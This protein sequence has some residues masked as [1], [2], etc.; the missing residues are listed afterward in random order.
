MRIRPDRLQLCRTRRGAPI[1]DMFISRIG[2][3]NPIAK[4]G[5]RFFIL[6]LRDDSPSHPVVFGRMPTS[7]RIAFLP[8]G[9]LSVLAVRELEVKRRREGLDRKGEF[10]VMHKF[11][12][13]QHRKVNEMVL[14]ESEEALVEF[15]A[16]STVS[17]TPS[18]EIEGLFTF[19]RILCYTALDLL[20][21]IYLYTYETKDGGIRAKDPRVQQT[22]HW[23]AGKMEVNEADSA[24]VGRDGNTGDQSS[25]L[26]CSSPT[27]SPRPP[28]PPPSPVHRSRTARERRI[29]RVPPP[30]GHLVDTSRTPPTL[31]RAI[32]SAVPEREV[33]MHSRMREEEGYITN[34]SPR[35]GAS[36]VG[37]RLSASFETWA[38]LTLRGSGEEKRG[39]ELEQE[40]KSYGKTG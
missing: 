10:F 5:V 29:I 2:H 33:R 15:P 28:P 13:S 34:L 22:V 40:D 38:H 17:S 36:K 24:V 18:R 7:L 30:S 8:R 26:S 31:H 12:G 35:S 32:D 14:K 23:G 21:Y 16:S 25:L 11:H 1:Q 27:P 9:R 3:H 37:C 20:Q 39:I 4:L 6:A 19:T